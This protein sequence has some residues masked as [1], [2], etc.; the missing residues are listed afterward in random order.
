MVSVLQVHGTDVCPL[1]D[2]GATPNVMS[3]RWLEAL[4]TRTKKSKKTVTVAN[5][6]SSVVL[7]KASEVPM[8][9]GEI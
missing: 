7:Q 8:R 3:P 6:S 2:S 1:I 9:L 5:G 4:S